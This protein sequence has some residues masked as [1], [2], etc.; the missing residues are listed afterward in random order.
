MFR[1]LSVRKGRNATNSTSGR[2]SNKNSNK[3]LI[4]C[5]VV[6][7]DGSDISVELS[8][9]AKA[10]DLYEQ[11]FYSLDLI[12]K[13]YFGLQ[14]TDANHV[15]HWLDPT[16]TIKKQIKIGPPYTLRLK[17]KFYSSE[18]NNLREELTRYQFF[19]Q[20]KQDILEGR[21]DCPPDIS[22]KLAAYALQSE[23]GDYDETQHTPAT[24]SE[25]RF[26]PNQTEQFE[27]DILEEFKKCKGLS[28]ASAELAY[29]NEAKWLEMYGVDMHTVLVSYFFQFL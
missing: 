21:L 18:P 12:E 11:V 20:L 26:V 22:V 23:L 8:K 3:N 5:K 15:K 27:I 4:Q 29:L 9:K 13:D 16:K 2:N 19:L 10:K 24:V 14:F 28:P 7:L 1:F 6:L 25:F 17:V